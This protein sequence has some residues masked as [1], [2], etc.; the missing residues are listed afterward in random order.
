VTTDGEHP[1]ARPEGSD[2]DMFIQWKGT[3]VC[4]DF[5]CPCGHEGHVDAGFAYFV[6]CGGCGAVYQM[7]TQ[8]IAKRVEPGERAVVAR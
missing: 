3:E 7:G 5:N 1:F 8:V 2:A 4:L 6:E